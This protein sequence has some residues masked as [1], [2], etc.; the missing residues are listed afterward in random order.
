MPAHAHKYNKQQNLITFHMKYSQW[1]QIKP[2]QA[3]KYN[4]QQI[5]FCMRYSQWNQIK[6]AHAHK[7]KY[8]KP[9]Q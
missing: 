5:T 1:N 4:K 7:H 2:A 9:Q 8:N 6:P 3:H